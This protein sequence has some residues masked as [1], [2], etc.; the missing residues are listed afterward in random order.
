MSK[1]LRRNEGISKT[2]DANPNAKPTI[3]AIYNDGGNNINIC[4]LSNFK[5]YLKELTINVA[6]AVC[7][8]SIL[9][10]CP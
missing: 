7:H 3:D 8:V 6:D 1:K 10:W 4:N 2:D 9:L 5:Y